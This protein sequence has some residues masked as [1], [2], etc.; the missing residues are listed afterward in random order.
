M[1]TKI[2]YNKKYIHFKLAVGNQYQKIFLPMSKFYNREDEVDESKMNK[3]F[4]NVFT[5][6]SKQM[7]QS[8]KIDDARLD[9][10]S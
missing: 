7:N 4:D 2:N 3:M 1:P 5:I 10:S 6:C 9:K 8:K